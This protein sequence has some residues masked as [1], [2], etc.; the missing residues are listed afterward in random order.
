MHNVHIVIIRFL[1]H[2][3]DTSMDNVLTDNNIANVKQLHSFL[4]E[5]R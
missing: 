2:Y 5:Y 3:V 1:F 4:F